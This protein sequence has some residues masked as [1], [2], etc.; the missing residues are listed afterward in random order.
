MDRPNDSERQERIEAYVSGKLGGED[1]RAFEQA[2]AGDDELRADLETERAMRETL[3]REPE[4]NFRELVRKVSEEQESERGDTGAPETPVIPIERKRNWTWI[5]AAA[6]IALVL[7]VGIAQWMRG[8]N[9]QELALA[10]AQQSV[11]TMRGDDDPEPYSGIPELDSALAHILAKQPDKALAV[12]ATYST[13]DP[14][15]SCKHDWLNALAL[16]QHG[17]EEHA[18]PLLDRVIGGVCHPEP[19]LAKELKGKL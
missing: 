15:L 1:L 10:F 4:M 19:G 14:A 12:L 3:Q 9:E 13:A 18:L 5:A 16:L 8:P 11:P 7:T 6:S 17:D 2:L